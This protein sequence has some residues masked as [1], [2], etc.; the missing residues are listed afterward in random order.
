MFK[1]A[2]DLEAENEQL[3]KEVAEFRNKN[4]PK[5]ESEKLKSL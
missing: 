2:S 3:K 5:S 1:T 4:N